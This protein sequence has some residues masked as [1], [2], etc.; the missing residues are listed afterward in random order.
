MYVYIVHTCPIP[1]EKHTILLIERY[2]QVYPSPC[3][4]SY[5][6]LAQECTEYDYLQGYTDN[7]YQLYSAYMII[8]NSLTSMEHCYAI[9]ESVNN[10]QKEM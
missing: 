5:N 1:T 3:T 10:T 7:S 4:C 9:I 8:S 2:L 6:C